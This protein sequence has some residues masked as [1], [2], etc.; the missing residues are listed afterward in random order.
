MGLWEC[1]REEETLGRWEGV[2]SKKGKG[3]KSGSTSKSTIKM[4]IKKKIKVEVK[5]E[6]GGLWQGV[7]S[8]K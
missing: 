8:Q 3:K 5:V 4:R 2:K 6:D 1:E 7:K